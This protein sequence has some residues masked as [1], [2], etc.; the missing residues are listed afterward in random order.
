MKQLFIS[1]K[2]ARHISWHKEDVREND[3]VMMDSS[4]N[5]AWNA[6]DDFDPDFIRD[7]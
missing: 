6:L 4:D 7:A 1:K 2:T 5:E 3:Q